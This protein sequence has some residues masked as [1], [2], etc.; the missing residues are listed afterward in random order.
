MR[1]PDNLFQASAVRE[2]KQRAGA[3]A[4]RTDA[5]RVTDRP[6]QDPAEK[7]LLLI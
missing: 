7:D 4:A 5:G 3:Q 6:G 1:N 2:R